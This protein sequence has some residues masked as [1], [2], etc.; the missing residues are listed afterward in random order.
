MVGRLIIKVSSKR[1]RSEFATY[2]YKQHHGISADLVARKWEILIDKAK[3]T[4]Q[5]TAQDNVRSDLKP[6]TWRYR[7]DLLLQ[8]ILLLNCIFYRNTLFAKENP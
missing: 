1:T 2:T 6:L 4:L 5:S 7:I 8:R 3:R